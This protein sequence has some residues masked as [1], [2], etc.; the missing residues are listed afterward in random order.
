[1]KYVRMPIEVE[2]P[3]EQ[4]YDTIRFNLSESSIRDRPLSDLR[5]KL[6]N[7]VLAYGAH[8][9]SPQLRTLIAERS[10]VSDLHVLTTAGAAGALFIIAT[11][12]LK[13]GDHLVVVRPNYA[14]NLETPRAIGCEI[15][16][17]DLKFEDGFALDVGALEKLLRPETRL[18]SVTTPHNPTGVALD[19]P[20][21]RAIIALGD[22]RGIRVL[23]DETYRDM[24][25]VPKPPVAASISPNAISVSSMSKSYGIPGVRVGWIV[26]QDV[27]LLE[28]FLAAKEQIGICGSIIDEEIA[29]VALADAPRFLIGIDKQ[30]RHALGIVE[31]WIAGEKRMEWVK[32]Q[33]GCVCF[34]RIRA[35]AGVDVEPFYKELAKRGTLVGAGHWFEQDRRFMRIGY[36]WPLEE[37]LKGGLAAISESLAA[38]AR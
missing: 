18:I 7:L 9:G 21:L 28:R 31:A 22:K 29:E 5:L 12:L 25:F 35:D 2:S 17:L 36:G 32:P 3:E 13:K 23:V 34:P 15:S 38:A 33:G 37:E 20:R 11:T 16:T 8:R 6:D 19:E 30:L 24:S 4:G 27:D 10:G 14:T 1:M 26:C